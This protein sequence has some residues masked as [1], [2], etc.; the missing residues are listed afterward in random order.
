MTGMGARLSGHAS[1]DRLTGMLDCSGYA[2]GAVW[3]T[4]RTVE[5]RK[6]YSEIRRR[7]KE[8]WRIFRASASPRGKSCGSRP[9]SPT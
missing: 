3:T 2:Y 1:A 4:R 9:T 7:E 5:R 6:Y 8:A